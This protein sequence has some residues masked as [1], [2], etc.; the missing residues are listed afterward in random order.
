MVKSALAKE[1]VAM[2]ALQALPFG[3]G[4]FVVGRSVVSGQDAI[5]EL[6][7]KLKVGIL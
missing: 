3:A 2:R 5:K 7:K 6:R 1:L 4:A